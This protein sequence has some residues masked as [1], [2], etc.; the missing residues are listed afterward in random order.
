MRPDYSHIPA[1]RVR[2]DYF[3]LDHYVRKMLGLDALKPAKP[4]KSWVSEG[5]GGSYF[6]F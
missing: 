5:G 3:C 6:H 1:V 2:I 4:C